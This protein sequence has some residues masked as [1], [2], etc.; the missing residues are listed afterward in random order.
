MVSVTGCFQIGEPIPYVD[1]ILA[2]FLKPGQMFFLEP[3]V[4]VVALGV[5]IRNGNAIFAEGGLPA[6]QFQIR[7]TNLG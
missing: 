3:L 6:M 7:C 1:D 4:D 2:S 5:E